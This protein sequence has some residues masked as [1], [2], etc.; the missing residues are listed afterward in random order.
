MSQVT[1]FIGS[2]E[3]EFHSIQ[4]DSHTL[5][6]EAKEKRVMLD[7]HIFTENGW[8]KALS[9]EHPKLLLKIS[10]DVNAY[11]DFKIAPPKKC[12]GLNE[13]VTDSGAQ[14]CL[15]SRE[16]YLD[17]GLTMNDLIPVS[18]SMK[19]A[20]SASIEIDGAVL[21]RLE[22][23]SSEGKKYSA[24]VMTYIS[25]DAKAFYLSKEALIQL[26]VIPKDFP[27]LGGAIA[28]HEVGGVTSRDTLGEIELAECGCPKRKPPPPKPKELPFPA[29]QEN[30]SRMKEWLLKRYASS[31]FNKCPHQVLPE[32]VGPPI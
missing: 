14:S 15:W 7:H 4:T 6:L 1:S 8:K 11:K 18:H 23:Q 22:G 3:S 32:M 27:R 19:A 16:D 26:G 24:S 28:D 29:T 21:L 10:T 25:P 17:L 12:E 30:V 5:G 13:V 9:F 2:V 20:N 31:A